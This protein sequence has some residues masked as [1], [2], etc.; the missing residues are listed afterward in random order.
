[1]QKE[2][3]RSMIE[4]L[5]VLAIIGVLSVGGIA[6]YSKAMMKFKINKTFEQ[7]S[8]TI[9]HVQTLYA[10]QHQKDGNKYYQSADGDGDYNEIMLPDDVKS[11]KN[12]WDGKYLVRTRWPDIDSFSIV[13]SGIP[14]SACI[15]LTSA[16]WGNIQTSGFV[17]I[18]SQ[19]ILDTDEA[20]LFDCYFEEYAGCSDD[21]EVY[22]YA[23]GKTLMACSIC[24]KK[25]IPVPISLATQ[26]CDCSENT[27]EVM[28]AFH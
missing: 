2:S 8:H 22:D 13:I 6:G 1:M 15:E 11:A 26:S 4:M 14:K 7:I 17:G 12:I 3:G 23:D 19:N 20:D 24:G 16:D 18:I 25:Q 5:G 27:C 21:N 9:T 10:S 28:L